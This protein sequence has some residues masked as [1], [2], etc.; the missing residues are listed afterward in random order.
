MLILECVCDQA[1]VVIFKGESLDA[2][3][4]AKIRAKIRLYVERA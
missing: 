2:K 4:Q 3:K 1:V